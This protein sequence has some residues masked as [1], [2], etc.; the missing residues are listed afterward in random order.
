MLLKYVFWVL[1]CADTATRSVHENLIILAIKFLNFFVAKL[2]QFC[3]DAPPLETASSFMSI[4]FWVVLTR[5]VSFLYSWFQRTSSFQ[6]HQSKEKDVSKETNTQ[7]TSS[8]RGIEFKQFDLRPL[9]NK[10]S[11]GTPNQ[12]SIQIRKWK[13]VLFLILLG[14]LVFLF[15]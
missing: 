4:V 1:K 11:T 3:F 9:K 15:N 12:R 10:S 2:F 6:A 13:F 14:I 5:S 8:Y 7:N